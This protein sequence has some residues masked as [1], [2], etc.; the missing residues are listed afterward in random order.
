MFRFIPTATT[1]VRQTFGKFTGICSPGLNLYIPIIQ[2]IT[3]V[4]N[5][6]MNKDFQLHVK[7]K[8]NVFTDLDIKVQ[9]KIKQEDTERAFFSLNNPDQQI[10]SYVQ[11]V[12]R[13]KVPTMKLDELFEAQTQ[14]GEYVSEHLTE[15]M[16]QYG[17]TIVDT[18]I[19]DIRPDKRVSTAMNEINAS[20]R[21]KMAAK[22]EA[23]AHYIREVRQ[24]EADK[25]RKI[26]QGEGISGQRLAI[27]GG[28][29]IGVSQMAQSLGLSSRDII[30]FVMKTQHLDTLESIGR[31]QNAKTIFMSHQPDGI[32]Q[33]DGLKNAIMEANDA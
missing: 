16:S 29:E 27:L 12:V 6:V 1:G 2:S 23:D 10:D 33:K 24:A 22:N 26:L 31:S 30:D 25:Q 17:Y 5:M 32:S 7:T 11:N 21:M 19:D 3:P 8:D 18:L 9:Y 14:I 15:K 28:Y 4:T 13:S 20:E